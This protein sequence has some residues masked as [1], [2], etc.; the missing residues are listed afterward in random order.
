MAYQMIETM[1]S[2][3]SSLEEEDVDYRLRQL[4]AATEQRLSELG[5]DDRDDAFSTFHGSLSE[6]GITEPG[7][8][9][10]EDEKTQ[11]V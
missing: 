3:T 4:D 8:I 9:G 11:E 10:G 6:L 7:F 1:H 5:Y 2:Q